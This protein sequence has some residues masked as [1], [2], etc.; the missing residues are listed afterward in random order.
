MCVLFTLPVSACQD[1]RDDPLAV[2]V[3]PETY[4][5]LLLSDALPSVPHLLA[6]RGL[7]VAGA[8]DADAWWESWTLEEH[9]GESLR[10]SIYPSAASRLY[11]VVGDEGVAELLDKQEESLAA[12]ER[13]S[14]IVGSPAIIQALEQAK[15]L[16]GE[17]VRA[18]AGDRGQEA[19]GLIL[20]TSD[21]LWEVS[22]QQVAAHLVNR[23][24]ETL[25][26][27]LVTNP[28]SE[29]ELLRIRRLTTGAQEALESG[30]YP[31]AIRRAYYACQLLGVDPP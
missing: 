16:H 2:A 10:A 26:R 15:R 6:E 21:A 17:A 22:P 28:Y 30:D 19:L 12:V 3:A 11:P 31:L 7:G 4:G 25:R 23:A 14:V 18:L 27:N 20:C 5:A 24:S 8:A 13:V 29:E 1:I 9:E